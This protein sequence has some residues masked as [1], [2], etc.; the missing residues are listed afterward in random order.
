MSRLVCYVCLS[1][2][3]FIQIGLSDD[4]RVSPIRS[5]WRA[6]ISE[7]T[8]T[9]ARS[10][11]MGARLAN[12]DPSQIY[13]ITNLR[14]LPAQVSIL[15]ITFEKWFRWNG[16]LR[17]HSAPITS[18]SPPSVRNFPRWISNSR[19]SGERDISIYGC[20]SHSHSSPVELRKTMMTFVQRIC[21]QG[22]KMSTVF[23][24]A[25]GRENKLD[26]ASYWH[27]LSEGIIFF[28]S[29][30]YLGP[31]GLRHLELDSRSQKRVDSSLSSC[32]LIGRAELI[33]RGPGERLIGTNLR[34]RFAF[35]S[36]F[37]T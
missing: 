18:I 36:H 27:L 21:L 4:G 15:G 29:R 2:D 35:A 8:P 10:G 6:S 19:T 28:A 16:F 3:N 24:L 13:F 34:W 14:C 7:S 25:L 30:P 32:R 9:A 31:A 33:T 20:R 1:V 37:S 11:L 22:R 12:F 23:G 26:V 5:V 17:A